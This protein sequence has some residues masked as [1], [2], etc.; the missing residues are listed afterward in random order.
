MIKNAKSLILVLIYK[1]KTLD[2][3]NNIV[4]IYIVSTQLDI[5]KRNTNP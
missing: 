4:R 5:T 3:D 2:H 1:I